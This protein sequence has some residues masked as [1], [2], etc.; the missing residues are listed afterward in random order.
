[1]NVTWSGGFAACA[2]AIAALACGAGTAAGPLSPDPNIRS[3]D[4]AGIGPAPRA[5]DGRFQN[6]GGPIVQ[7][8]MSVTLP[9]F[10]RRVAA[11]FRTPLGLP[12]RVAA[13]YTSG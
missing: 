2:M 1:M 4:F 5:A 8:G 13:S 3:H 7:A 10:A 6:P 9:F 11:R 12:R